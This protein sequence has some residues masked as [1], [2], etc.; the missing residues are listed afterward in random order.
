MENKGF[1]PFCI[2]IANQM[3]TPSRPIPRTLALKVARHPV[4]ILPADQ[5]ILIGGLLCNTLWPVNS[6]PEVLP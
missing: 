3:P 4:G 5:A 6:S 1:E 2:L